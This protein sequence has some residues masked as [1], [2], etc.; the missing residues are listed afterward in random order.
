MREGGG[1]ISEKQGSLERRKQKGRKSKYRLASVF[2][3]QSPS[4]AEIKQNGSDEE[5]KKSMVACKSVM[6]LEF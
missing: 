3:E 4:E 2:Q 1:V 5:I 6:V